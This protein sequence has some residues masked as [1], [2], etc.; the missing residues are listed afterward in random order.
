MYKVY[1]NDM[2]FPVTPSKITTKFSNKNTTTT[3][4]NDGEVSI[5]KTPGLTEIS[6][7]ALLPQQK[8]P[9]AVYENGF[10]EAQYFLLRLSEIKSSK[11]P[12]YLKILRWGVNGI[13][14]FDTNDFKCS[15]ENYSINEDAKKDGFDVTV[16]ISLKQ[17]RDFGTEKLVIGADGKA[18]VV[19]ERPTDKD[20]PS[21][22]NPMTYTVKE[23]DLDLGLWGI[24]RRLYGSG[25][26]VRDIAEKNGISNPN[27]LT[28]GQV[29]TLE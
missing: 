15:L 6:F 25:S 27:K 19:N 1:L 21:N 29:I 9:F 3:L 17:Y 16:S 14:S 12:V 5:L 28:K 26:N 23:S 24:C 18:V 20:K 10:K 7:E 8:Y 13:K 11:K 4:I 22:S 2:L